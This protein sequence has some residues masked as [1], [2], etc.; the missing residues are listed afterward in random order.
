MAGVVEEKWGEVYRERGT[1]R[2]YPLQNIKDL[3]LRSE[4]EYEQGNPG[5][6]NTVYLFS[7]IALFVL[8]IACFNFINLSTA[9][10]A[11]RAREV[12]MRKVMG[13]QKGQIV[14]QFLS[15]S[16]IMSIFG[17]LI[18]IVLV[19]I[20]LPIFNNLA[21]KEFDSGQLLSSTV[22]IGLLAIIII[23]G[24]IAGNFPAFVL[25]AFN[26]VMVLKGKLSSASRN[27]TLEK[28]TGRRSI[29]HFHLYDR[30]DYWSS[31]DSWIISRIEIWDSTKSI[32]S[33]SRFLA[34]FKTNR[35]P[36]DIK[37]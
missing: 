9:R 27:M 18:G 5:D 19:Q 23:T 31:S 37:L 10:S 20:A 15:E 4:A 14:R 25:S 7:A 32:W 17:L 34:T 28:N 30:R 33:L 11:S 22:L 13:S 35:A 1:S 21:V 6:I 24:V 16:I 12:G 8:F 26:P 36:E 29:F 2:Q 3:H